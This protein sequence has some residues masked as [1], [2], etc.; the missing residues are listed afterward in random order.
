M[1]SRSSSNLSASSFTSLGDG[2]SQ[3]QF[4]HDKDVDEAMDV[5]EAS[6]EKNINDDSDG[7]VSDGGY[8][9]M[10]IHSRGKRAQYSAEDRTVVTS[11][12]LGLIDASLLA[13]VDSI[14]YK[15]GA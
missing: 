8:D 10:S 9:N 6:D 7:D 1:L 5:V 3:L 12:V 14:L 4:D 13:P 15:N 11:P 2:E